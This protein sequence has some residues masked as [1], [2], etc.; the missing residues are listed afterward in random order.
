MSFQQIMFEGYNV[1]AFRPIFSNIYVIDKDGYKW[2]QVSAYGWLREID[3]FFWP[4][5]PTNNINLLNQYPPTVWDI[6]KARKENTIYY[7]K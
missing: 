4:A 6:I 1:E 2:K 7:Y 3:K 5:N